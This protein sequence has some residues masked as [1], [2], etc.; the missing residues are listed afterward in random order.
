MGKTN[1]DGEKILNIKPI[2][3]D[4]PDRKSTSAIESL[5]LNKLVPYS[6][7]PFILYEGQRFTDMVESVRANGVLVPIVVRSVTEEGRYEILS[8][9]NRVEAARAV[10][11]KSIP[12]IIRRGLTDE[13]ALLIVT[14]TNLM[15]RSFADLKHSEK[16]IALATHYYAMKKNPGYR[17]DLLQEIEDLS[18]VPVGQRLS[19]RG[20][21]SEQHGLSSTSIQRYLRVNKLSKELKQWLDD[22]GIAMRVAEALSF[23]REKEQKIVEGLLAAGNKISMKQANN[24]RV[25]SEKSSLNKTDIA[26]IMKSGTTPTRSK[27]V[28]LSM[29]LFSLHFKDGQSAE[30]IEKIIGEALKKY[31]ST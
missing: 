15:Q 11:I 23:L 30:E 18:S 8:G 29:D 22:G 2:T 4:N 13:E 26:K 16:A 25:A 12:A 27:T 21:L 7:H 20:T 9:H 10:G 6:N 3:K 1:D 14:E 19:T 5:N 28:K 17:T 24:I 31:L